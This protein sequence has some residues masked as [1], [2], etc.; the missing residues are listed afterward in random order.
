MDFT[1]KLQLIKIGGE[2]TVAQRRVQETYQG[3]YKKILLLLCQGKW[4]Q[5]RVYTLDQDRWGI[6]WSLASIESYHSSLDTSVWE[7]GT[8]G[9]ISKRL[10]C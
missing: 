4:Y 10:Y 5:S 2:P 7:G 8:A 9:F 6:W 3:L 1:S